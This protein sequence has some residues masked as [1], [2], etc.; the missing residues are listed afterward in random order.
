MFCFLALAIF[1]IMG[2]FS[3][4]HR[5]LAKE[6][7]GC[8]FRRITFKPCNVDLKAKIKGKLVGK[9]LKKSVTGAKLLNKYFEVIA[10]LFVLISLGSLGWVIYGGYN[11]YYYGSCNGLNSSGFC[12]FD[13]SGSNNETSTISTTCSL[14]N[15][16]VDDLTLK[17]VNLSLFTNKNDND[18][19]DEVV[20]IGC[21]SCEF[22]RNAYPDIQKLIDK[23]DINYYFAHYPAKDPDDYLSKVSYCAQK[24]DKK[25]FWSLNDRLFEENEEDIHVSSFVN[26]I[27]EDV[28]YDEKIIEECMEDPLT[29]DGIKIQVAEIEKTHIYGTPTVFINEKALVGP[30]PYRVYKKQL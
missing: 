7:L 17:D 1:S 4:T 15:P 30:K 20:F 26:D 29:E 6:A 3:A 27:L 25:K 8:V 11:Y 10:W 9:L 21:Y 18:A 13:P 5:E 14:E 22:S 2:L 23:N 12:A 24:E 16:T 28:G 19:E